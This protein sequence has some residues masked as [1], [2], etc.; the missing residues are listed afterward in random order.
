MAHTARPI[1]FPRMVSSWTALKMRGLDRLHFASPK[2]SC[3]GTNSS[4]GRAAFEDLFLDGLVDGAGYLLLRGDQFAGGL[5]RQIAVQRAVE[6][7]NHALHIG[8]QTQVF[9]AAR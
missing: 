2:P 1:L 5:A 4:S 3:R 6:L 8:R 9:H 7:G